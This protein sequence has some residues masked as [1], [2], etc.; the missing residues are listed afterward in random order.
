[1][2]MWRRKLVLCISY[3]MKYRQNEARKQKSVKELTLQFSMIFQIRQKNNTV[4]FRV[5]CPSSC[6][7]PWCAL[8]YNFLLSNARR[9]YCTVKRRMLAL[10]GQIAKSLNLAELKLISELDSINVLPPCFWTLHQQCRQNV[11]GCPRFLFLG[12]ESLETEKL[13]HFQCQLERKS[14]N[15]DR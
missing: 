3:K 12:R 7:V 6:I 14:N 4:N 9:F 11:L 15:D 8:L 1:M 2:Y 13:C 10:N 5:I